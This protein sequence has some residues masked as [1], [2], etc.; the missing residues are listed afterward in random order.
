M[1]AGTSHLYTL[2]PIIEASDVTGQDT[3]EVAKAY[4]A[5]GSALDLTWYLQQITNL[6]VENNWQALACEAFPRRPRLAAAGDHRLGVADAGR[7]EG[8]RG[9]RRPVAG[10]TPA[11]G[12]A[13][14]GDAGRTACRV[15][16]DYAMYAVA[17]RE[18]MD[19]AQSSQHGV[20]IP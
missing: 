5:V 11:A 7:T 17:N 6:P 20:C 19:L 2:L 8:G 12:R 13:L 1:V 10:T 3:A 18:L 16:T 14:A 4:F 15:G 9:A